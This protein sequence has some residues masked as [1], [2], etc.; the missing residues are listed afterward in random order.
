MIKDLINKLYH[1]EDWGIWRQGGLE[2]SY[3]CKS[4]DI[5]LPK[6][7]ENDHECTNFRKAQC[8]ICFEDFFSIRDG[9]WRLKCGHLL[10]GDWYDT[11][12]KTNLNCPLWKKFAFSDK[13]KTIVNN[14][15]EE[16]IKN[17][18]MSRELQNLKVSILCNDCNEHS[19][20]SFNI[21]AFKCSN[22]NGYN[23]TQTKNSE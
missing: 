18:V 23:T 8:P 15:I 3:H 7:M 17:T 1:C 19:T 5:C 11:Y 6:S 16:Q 2:N 10:H 21:V 12:F 14:Q 13:I 20:T 9:G 22:C 4:W